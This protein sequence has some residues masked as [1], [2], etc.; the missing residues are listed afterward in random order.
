MK[1]DRTYEERIKS[2]KREQKPSNWKSRARKKSMDQWAVENRNLKSSPT[3]TRVLHVN[4]GNITHNAI[5]QRKRGVWKCIA[6]EG[7]IEWMSRVRTMDVIEG[8]LRNHHFSYTWG[9][10]E[11]PSEA[12]EFPEQGTSATDTRLKNTP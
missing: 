10:V 11:T 8:W 1:D 7:S 3:I 4:Y 12:L 2:L 9:Q 5:F 6:A